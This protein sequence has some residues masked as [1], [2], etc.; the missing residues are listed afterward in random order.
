MSSVWVRRLDG[1]TRE[2]DLDQCEPGVFEIPAESLPLVS[3]LARPQPSAG[4][5]SVLAV[6]ENGLVRALYA[7]LGFYPHNPV[8]W[9]SAASDS[10][11]LVFVA[12]SESWGLSAKPERLYY[13]VP[14]KCLAEILKLAGSDAVTRAL[15]L[16]S[17]REQTAGKGSKTVRTKSRKQ[18]SK[19]DFD[20]YR[21][22]KITGWIEDDAA[23]KLAVN[24]GTVS[25]AVNR[26]GAWLEAGNVLPHDMR[27]EPSRRKP[28]AM[29]PGQLDKG[30]RLDHRAAHQRGKEDE[31]S[32]A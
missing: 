26:V 10:P 4:G 32:R 5:L 14:P 12:V 15:W 23:K 19:R 3:V 7:E 20:A 25:R 29:D 28:V 22:V 18:P 17:Q 11:R 8:L 30:S 6:A 2:V 1:T 16:G 13:E 21:L 24:Q 31:G 27:A 9:R